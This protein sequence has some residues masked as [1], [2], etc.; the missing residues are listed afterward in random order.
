[1]SDQ[2]KDEH[3]VDETSERSVAETSEGSVAE[4]RV[5]DGTTWA[6]FCDTLKTAGGVITGSG[7]PKDPFERAEGLRYLSRV[8]RAALEA[9]VEHGD[10]RAPALHRPVHETVKMGADNPDMIY[11]NAQI[12]GEHDYL[13]EGK[14]G[15]VAYLGLGSYAGNYGMGGGGRSGETGYLEAKDLVLGDDGALEVLLS[16]NEPA[17]RDDGRK[18]NWLPMADDTSSLIVRQLFLDR[19]RETPAELTLRRVSADGARLD[20]LPTPLSCERIDKQLLSAARLVVGA[21]GLF[22]GWSMGFQRHENELPLFEQKTA[23]AAH[24][25]PNITYYHSYW[26]LEAD[27]ALLVETTPPPCDYWNFQLNNHWMESLD[28]RFHRI[29]INKA[30]A[31][32][33]DDGS[34]RI[35]VAHRDPGLPNW[36][37]T[38]GHQR[39]T[40][41]FRWIRARAD[42]P[43]P[44]TRVV[45]LDELAALRDREA[46]GR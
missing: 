3:S 12:S 23:M 34:V 39:G 14:R 30:Q 17:P 8:T 40:M 38:A 29:A 18:V 45:T 5:M 11:E 36:L 10:P 25:D 2:H 1:V 44:R 15:S 26:R 20:A 32:Y 13:L 6:E 28:Y 46:A 41:C 43:Q 42:E 31:R 27:Q 33:Q 4:A 16:R 9:F 37:S 21:V 7:S 24:G 19:E 35:V 22:T